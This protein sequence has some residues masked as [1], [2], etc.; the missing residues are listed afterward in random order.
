M[1]RRDLIRKGFDVV[2][3]RYLEFT[4]PHIATRRSW[5]EQAMS[6][7]RPGSIVLDLGCGAMPATGALAGRF[8]LVGVDLS[9]TQLQMARSATAGA[10]LVVQG[11]MAEIAVR[12]AS[13][14]AVV[15]MWAFMHLPREEQP[16]LLDRITRWLEP[17]GVLLASFGMDDDP[18][19]VEDFLGVPMFFSHFDA[20][21]TV[22][23][24]EAAGLVI[25]K[26]DVVSEPDGTRAPWVLARRAG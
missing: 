14:G 10:A 3:E 5:L 23:Q 7:T 21:E 6:L 2:A 4:A 26:A 17:G 20:D 12:H 15:S 19:T 13:L 1:A 11:D 16:G 9:T 18:G 22:R 8:A 25:V 24:V